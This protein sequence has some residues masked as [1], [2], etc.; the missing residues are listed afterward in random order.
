MVVSR[1]GASAETVTCSVSWPTSSVNR[2]GHVSGRRPA[3][4]CVCFA[5]LN[6]CSSTRHFVV[7]GIEQRRLEVAGAVGDEVLADLRVDVRDL[8][9]GAG[10]HGLTVANRAGDVAAS[11]LRACRRGSRTARRKADNV[12]RMPYSFLGWSVRLSSGVEAGAQLNARGG[13]TLEPF[14]TSQQPLA[15]VWAQ[16]SFESAGTIALEPVPHNRKSIIEETH[17]HEANTWRMNQGLPTVGGPVTYPA[18]DASYCA[19]RGPG[20]VCDPRLHQRSRVAAVAR[21]VQHRHGRGRRAAPVGRER[22]HLATSRSPGAGT[23]RRSS[24]ATGCF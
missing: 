7:A 21:P 3:R 10:N 24:P 15:C 19:R 12:R 14:N 20:P 2:Q 8:H 13:N 9:G 16:V 6:P 17:G 4:C 22:H 11:F 5:G 18:S 1:S 23:R